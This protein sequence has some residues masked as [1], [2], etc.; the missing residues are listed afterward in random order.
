MKRKKEKNIFDEIKEINLAIFED[1]FILWQNQL[2]EWLNDRTKKTEE[3]KE[4]T[5]FFIQKIDL[6]LN[7]LNDISWALTD[8]IEK[9]EPNGENPAWFP[10]KV[11]VGLM[12]EP[13]KYLGL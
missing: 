5:D 3:Q 6:L 9:R 8:I 10:S 2:E 7:G 13:K 1:T 11:I 12:K 4:K